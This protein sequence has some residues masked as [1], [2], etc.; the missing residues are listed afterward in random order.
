MSENERDLFDKSVTGI[1]CYFEFGT[2]GS[3]VRVN[4]INFPTS[5]HIYSID[6][7]LEWIDK[8]RLAVDFAKNCHVSHINIRG[9]IGDWGYPI[10]FDHQTQQ[11][12]KPVSE[13]IKS[14]YWTS[15]ANSIFTT[16]FIDGILPEVIFV[17]GRWRVACILK[18][19]LFAIENNIQPVIMLHDSQ[20]REYHKVYDYLNLEDRVE[21]M[22]VYSLK[23]EIDVYK[24]ELDYENFKYIPT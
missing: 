21:C 18:S 11:F 9:E 1:S 16:E 15:Y 3:A 7:S 20:R 17:D 22:D 24:V 12:I 10:E 4:E 14:K 2:G 13:E 8:V 5:P 6:T 19:I 23:N